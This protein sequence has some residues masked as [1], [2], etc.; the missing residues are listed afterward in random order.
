MK[1]VDQIWGN[2]LNLHI[3]NQTLVQS[4]LFH[5]PLVESP[6]IKFC[7]PSITVPISR[8]LLGLQFVTHLQACHIFSPKAQ[9]AQ[10]TGQ[11]QCWNLC[12]CL[13]WTRLKDDLLKNMLDGHELEQDDWQRHQSNH[14]WRRR[15]PTGGRVLIL[16]GGKYSPDPVYGVS[17]PSLMWDRHMGHLST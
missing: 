10:W 17:S 3:P 15:W 9:S 2:I 6:F 8:V 11:F 16:L 14:C 4:I 12:L 1:P 5:K 7:S 13:K